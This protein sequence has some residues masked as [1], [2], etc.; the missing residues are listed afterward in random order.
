MI[1]E[2]GLCVLTYYVKEEKD[3]TFTAV[4]A[5]TNFSSEDVAEHM[6]EEMHKII[7]EKLEEEIGPSEELQ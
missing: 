5:F 6:A 1:F 4:V 2:N 3:K 7:S